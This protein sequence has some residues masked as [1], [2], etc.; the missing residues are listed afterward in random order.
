MLIVCTGALSWCNSQKV[1]VLHA[2]TLCKKCDKQLTFIVRVIVSCIFLSLY[3]S[4]LCP[5]ISPRLIPAADNLK[6]ELILLNG[7]I[8][9]IQ[10][11]GSTLN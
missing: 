4:E 7:I 1:F 8:L 6:G 10:S 3:K 9:C 11:L 2:G 5:N